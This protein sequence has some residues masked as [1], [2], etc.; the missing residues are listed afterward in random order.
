MNG[1]IFYGEERTIQIMQKEGKGWLFYV[2]HNTPETFDDY[3]EY[4]TDNVLDPTE[5]TSAEAFINERERIF[6]E[7]LEN[8]CA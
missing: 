7:A 5:E 4:C 3:L 8:H 1:Q 6:E 2:S